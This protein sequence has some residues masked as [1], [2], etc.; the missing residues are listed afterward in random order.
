MTETGT[1]IQVKL[2]SR[3]IHLENTRRN[4]VKN[5]GAASKS[6]HVAYSDNEFDLALFVRPG[7]WSENEP[8]DWND[9]SKWDLLAIPVQALKDPN[10]PGF[11]KRSV[12]KKLQRKYQN[13]AA[14]I[15]ELVENI[16]TASIY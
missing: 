16:K 11:I 5:Q 4:S 1:R 6:G 15:I 9:T 8:N 13:K 7:S 10:N 14:Q 2:R 12:S 3:T